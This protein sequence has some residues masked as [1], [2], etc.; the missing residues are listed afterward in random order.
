MSDPIALA[1]HR[2]RE[3]GQHRVQLGWVKGLDHRLQVLENGV[4]FDGHIAGAQD[5][6]GLQSHRTVVVGHDE[7]DELGPKR[8]RR[9]DLGLDVARQILEY[10][11]ID[12]QFQLSCFR[13]RA[14]RRHLSHLHTAQLHLGA[15]F[16]HQSRS[17]RD[18]R[19][20]DETRIRRRTMPRSA[21]RDRR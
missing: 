5:C 14:D 7:I 1:T 17:V 16:H 15:V 18:H 11:R 21:Q 4:D 19:E 3:S 2:L 10:V 6:A 20:W 8:G 12:L 9:F 13:V